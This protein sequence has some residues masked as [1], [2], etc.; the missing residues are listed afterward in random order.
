MRGLRMGR[1]QGTSD[2]VEITN[3]FMSKKRATM[4]ERK[5]AHAHSSVLSV[6]RTIII[7]MYVDLCD[8]DH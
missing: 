2:E 4:T 7:Y 3:H 5:D 8:S 6:T 1:L